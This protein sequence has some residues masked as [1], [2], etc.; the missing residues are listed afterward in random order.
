MVNTMEISNYMNRK[1]LIGFIFYLLPCFFISCKSTIEKNEDSIKFETRSCYLQGKSCFNA[2]SL[3]VAENH[4]QKAL[5]I[6]PFFA[7][8]YE[9]LGL[10]AIKKGD[11][12]KAELLL[13]KALAIDVN[14]IPAEID[15]L[16]LNIK[17]GKFS[18]VIDDSEKI[19]MRLN[20]GY[21]PRIRDQLIRE[22]KHWK[23]M[24]I[25]GAKSSLIYKLGNWEC[26][27]SLK[28][29]KEV[30]RAEFTASLMD[31]FSVKM[32]GMPI[33]TSI[34]AEDLQADSLYYPQIMQAVKYRI[35][36]PYPDGLFRSEHKMKRAEIALIINTFL[37]KIS[38]YEK[39]PKENNC[40]IV[41]IPALSPVYQPISRVVK[42]GIM[43]CQNESHFYP[44][45][46]VSGYELLQILF[47]LQQ[48]IGK[49]S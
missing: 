1:H 24:A 7:P 13:Q 37:K 19:I 26:L 8:A 32:V 18:Q 45:N 42:R 43:L 4:F 20:S 33:E 15:M 30:S 10:V 6:N 11:Y 23:N 22:T 29:K 31:V 46:H 9:G 48:I 44:D 36:I 49:S 5:N 17:K 2:D 28:E 47:R 21:N 40:T 12:K 3:D 14:W 41:D 39:I 35:V 16:Q 34:K 25:K 38:I 27:K